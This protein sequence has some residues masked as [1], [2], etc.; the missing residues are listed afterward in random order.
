MAKF[1][2]DPPRERRRLAEPVAFDADEDR[3]QEATANLLYT[4][5]DETDAPI[6]DWYAPMPPPFLLW[7]V[8]TIR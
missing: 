2:T 6:P 5:D 8:A 4:L 7:E 3:W 1:G